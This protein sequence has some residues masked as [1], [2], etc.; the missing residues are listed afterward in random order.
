MRTLQHVPAVVRATPELNPVP[1][2]V[3]LLPLRLSDVPDVEIARLAIERKA[4]RIAQPRGPD[5]RAKGV[6]RRDQVRTIDVQA[7]QL[8][9][10]HAQ[11]LRVVVR[12]AAPTSV[13]G[14]CVQLAVGTELELSPVVVVVRRMRDR[15]ERVGGRLIGDVWV[16]RDVIPDDADVAVPVVQISEETAVRRVLRVER[17]AQEP[18]LTV[19]SDLAAHI[20][21]WSSDERVSF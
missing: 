18:T 14:G 21:E 13:A 12:V 16:R 4:P 6:V 1:R 3:D 20:E 7:Q 5:L 19:G 9:E 8:A 11:V 15:D 2:D 17:D 10:Q